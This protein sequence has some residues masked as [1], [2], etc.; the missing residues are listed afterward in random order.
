MDSYRELKVWRMGMQIVV[1]VYDVTGKFPADE[2]FGLTSQLR[3]C[4]ISIPSNIAEGHARGAT[5]DM[6]R[7]LGI[8]RGSLAELE[9]QLILAQQLGMASKDAIDA[10]MRMSDEES[11][12]ISGLRRP[13]RRK[14]IK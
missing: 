6:I 3:R 9:T 11:R 5:K 14:I 13:L 10:L 1:A 12:M 7:F 2:R 8:A 4:A